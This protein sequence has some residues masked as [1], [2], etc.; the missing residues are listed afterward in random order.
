MIS[1]L[2]FGAFFIYFYQTVPY[3]NIYLHCLS[4]LKLIAFLQS[5]MTT[6]FF[7][8]VQRRP[9]D[10]PKFVAFSEQKK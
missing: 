7:F 4:Q 1:T 10:R 6:L 5:S 9:T 2:Y 3:N 8:S